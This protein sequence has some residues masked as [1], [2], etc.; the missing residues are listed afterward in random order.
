MLPKMTLLDVAPSLPDGVIISCIL[1]KNR[2]IKELLNPQTAGVPY[3]EQKGLE[4]N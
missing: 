3:M 1:D 2:Q 4:S